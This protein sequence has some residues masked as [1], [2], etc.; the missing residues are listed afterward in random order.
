MCGPMTRLSAD[1]LQRYLIIYFV[2]TFGELTEVCNK[3]KFCGIQ[4]VKPIH[5][6]F[7]IQMSSECIVCL[8]SATEYLFIT[9]AQL[10]YCGILPGSI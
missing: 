5:T 10:A 4:N 6:L 9:G 8:S 2:C 3:L 1:P 7:L